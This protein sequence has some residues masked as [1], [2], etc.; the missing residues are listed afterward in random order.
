MCANGDVEFD[1]DT[2][3]TFYGLESSWN[4]SHCNWQHELLLYVI[5]KAL[6]YGLKDLHKQLMYVLELTLC[7][8]DH[9]SF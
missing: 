8:L 7:F 9:N 6:K 2:I 3:K 5:D 4:Y 1:T